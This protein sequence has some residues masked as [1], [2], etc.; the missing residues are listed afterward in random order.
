[1]KKI[2]RIERLAKKEEKAIVKRIFWLSIVSGGL[3]IAVFT[4][5]IPLLGNFADVLNSIF[6]DKI[7]QTA[8]AEA[9]NPPVFDILP[10]A[11]NQELLTVT[12][13]ASEGVKVEV[14]QDAKLIGT[15]AVENGKFKYENLVLISGE[16]KISLKAISTEDK[17]SDFSQTIAII[18]DKVEPTLEVLNPKDGQEFNGNNRVKVEGKTDSDSQVFAN[19]F[20]ANVDTEGNFEVTIPLVEGES[21]IEVKA[22]DD[23]GNTKAVKVKVTFRK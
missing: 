23:A 5:G 15:T 11:T 2:N 4:I 1:M 14:Y 19:G 13:F 7:S 3:I 12:G 18:L 16:N 10:P 8:P 17:S 9:P 20:L 21:D 6:G 22:L